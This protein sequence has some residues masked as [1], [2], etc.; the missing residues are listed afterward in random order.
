MELSYED[1]PPVATGPV[2]YE[3]LKLLTKA[4]SK[5]R[6]LRQLRLLKSADWISQDILV[7]GQLTPSESKEN[8]SS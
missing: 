7:I 2:T 4:A 5:V 6:P 8:N 3:E 1:I